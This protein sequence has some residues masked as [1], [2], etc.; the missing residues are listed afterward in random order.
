MNN[1]EEKKLYYKSLAEILYRYLE[2][3][4]SFDNHKKYSYLSL[5]PTLNEIFINIINNIEQMEE[6][7]LNSHEAIDKI[8]EMILTE[9]SREKIIDIIDIKEGLSIKDISNLSI[10]LYLK[11]FRNSIT[12][13]LNSML[14]IVSS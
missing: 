4:L 1:T 3:I 6:L 12:D 13:E 9:L 14:E 10:A 11:K 7:H 2:F 5:L 8:E